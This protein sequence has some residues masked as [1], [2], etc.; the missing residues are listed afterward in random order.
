MHRIRRKINLQCRRNE[1]FYNYTPRMGTW[2]NYLFF[3][4]AEE[5]RDDRNVPVS[6]RNRGLIGSL[7]GTDLDCFQA[8]PENPVVTSRQC[9]QVPAFPHTSVLEGDG[10]QN[11]VLQRR[12]SHRPAISATK[13]TVLRTADFQTFPEGIQQPS[14]IR[15][16]V[17]LWHEPDRSTTAKNV[18]GRQTVRG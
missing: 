1:N 10:T 17:R 5:L 18:P 7:S 3:I 6:L 12:L 14:G 15:R 11:M 8:R 9:V 4:Y 2:K 13:R 16:R